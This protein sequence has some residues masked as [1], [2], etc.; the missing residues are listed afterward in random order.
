MATA[1]RSS[2]EAR[3][4]IDAFG[5]TFENVQDSLKRE[6]QLQEN[7]LTTFYS[8]HS[9]VPVS[10]W[11]NWILLA[12]DSF[13]VKSISGKPAV[14]A[15]Y[16]WF[17]PWGRDTFISL[18]GLLLVTGRFQTAKNILSNYVQYCKDGLIPNFISDRS[19]EPA[20][21]TVDATLW[22]IN[23]VFQYLKYTGNF[24]FVKEELWE[25]LKA[26]IACHEKGT[27]F[28]IHVDTDGLLMH[29]PRLTWMDAFVDSE[30]ITPR[31][32]KAVDIQALWYNALR[33]MEFLAAK[34][35]E[36]NLAKKYAEMADKTRE[37][38]NSK[39]WNAQKKCLFDVLEESGVDDSIRPNQIFSLSLD[40]PVLDIEKGRQVVN[41]V[42]REL[43]T[44]YGL[45]TLA[46]SDRKF[47]G[48]YA[49]DRRSRDTA[50]HNGTIWPWLIGPFV[51]AF[52]K[53]KGHEKSTRK[54]AC[55]NFLL[56]LF[57]ATV[58]QGGLGTINEIYDGSAPY[59][60]QGCIA[61]AWSVAEPLRAYLEGVLEV[62]PEFSKMF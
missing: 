18:P 30:A 34:F 53:V 60:P 51:S 4:I 20:Y 5:N 44:V 25:K 28:N 40:F 13:I 1:N 12:A 7:L 61:Q 39:F 24:K 23:A 27:L 33:I 17:E 58:H 11:L 41:L 32:G 42:K 45:R 59:N 19:G 62:K 10:D 16:Q 47:V 3:V 6:L 43:V 57:N 14:I 26:I 48:K 36:P 15:G 46:T 56:P 55:E 2:Q 31:S 50:Y 49:G 38:F 9:Q 21:N 22:Y 29:G 52:F 8:S 54:F 35:S 37:N